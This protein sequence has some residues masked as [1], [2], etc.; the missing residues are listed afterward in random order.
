ME[1]RNIS[2]VARKAQMTWNDCRMVCKTV[3]ATCQCGGNDHDMLH[4]SA[5]LLSWLHGN[6]NSYLSTNCTAEHSPYHISTPFMHWHTF[7]SYTRQKSCPNS[8]G[9]CVE[10]MGGKEPN[11][12][13]VVG[14]MIMWWEPTVFGALLSEF[15]VRRGSRQD[16]TKFIGANDNWTLSLPKKILRLILRWEDP[17]RRKQTSSSSSLS[18]L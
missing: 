1:K 12:V 6:Q 3:R 10:G 9:E 14:W 15:Q 16:G 17:L 2:T 7:G 13:C 8:E 11:A 18:D 5:L 4:P